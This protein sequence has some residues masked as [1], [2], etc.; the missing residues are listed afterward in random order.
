MDFLCFLKLNCIHVLQGVY[1]VVCR[2]NVSL[3]EYCKVVAVDISVFL[4]QYKL[5]K[6]GQF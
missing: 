5:N 4:M 1:A 2:F 3:P 6:K